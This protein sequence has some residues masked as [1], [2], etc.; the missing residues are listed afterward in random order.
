MSVVCSVHY[1]T[2]E[3]PFHVQYA[4]RKTLEISV[5]PNGDV[6]VVAPKGADLEKIMGK[7]K[8]R[9]RWILRQKNFFAQFNP[10]TPARQY[11]AGETHMYL[12]KQFRLK[13]GVSGN[14]KVRLS[15]GC[16]WV[17]DNSPPTPER[18]A[19]LIGAWYRQKAEL[20][21]TTM[22]G[23]LWSRFFNASNTLPR[24]QV[25]KMRTRWGSLSKGGILTLNPD[26]VRAPKECIEYVICHELCHLRFHD[27]SREFYKLL[28]SWMPDWEMRKLKLEQ[29]LV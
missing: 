20:L 5:V 28:S 25:K 29:A 1:G 21:F 8:K 14:A 13:L 23:L 19:E 27:H 2:K 16:F 9:A 15:G 22:L 12:G 26:L 17:D 18:I 6:V 7:V 11:L 24:L 10:R 3:I 4:A